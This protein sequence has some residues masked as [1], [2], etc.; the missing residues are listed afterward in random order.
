M[1]RDMQDPGSTPRSPDAV[2]AHSATAR[3]ASRASRW[4]TGLIVAAGVA[5]LAAGIGF[6]TADLHVQTVLSGSM[7]PTISPGDLAITQ[8]VPADAVRVGDVIVFAPPD[9]T[10]PVLHRVASREGDV[11]TTKG[12]ANSVADPWRIR[13]A[14]STGYRLVVVVP[15][16]G[17]LTQLRGIALVA[18]GLIVALLILLE[19]RKGV[20]A[21]RSQ[22]AS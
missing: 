3:R 19:M 8:A 9:G 18:A 12:D 14:D 17:W 6:R 11:L 20:G 15:L 4:R 1:A 21:R 22:I 16:L 10:Q 2:Q 5:C 7:R 13:L